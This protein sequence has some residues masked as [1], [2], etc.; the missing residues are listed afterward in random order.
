MGGGATNVTTDANDAITTD[1]VY[2]DASSDNRST[3]I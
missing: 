1:V 3:S 2:V